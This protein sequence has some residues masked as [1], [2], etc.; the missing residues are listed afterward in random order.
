VE[1]L[2]A[3]LIDARIITGAEIWGLVYGW[4]EV[5]T[6]HELYCKRVVRCH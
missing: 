2:Y 3:S 5:G 1:Q 6:V 4:E